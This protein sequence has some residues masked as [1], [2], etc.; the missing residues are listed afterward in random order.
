MRA[1]SRRGR[2]GIT[3]G[4]AG[5][6]AWAGTLLVLGAPAAVVEAAP[7]ASAK[8]SVAGLRYSFAAGG[9][10]YS[11]KVSSLKSQGVKCTTARG[12][13]GRV[14]VDLL[15]DKAVPARIGGLTVSLRM[16]CSG[17]APSYAGVAT[18]PGSRVSF[19]ILGGA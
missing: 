10:T 19:V 9:A 4:R 7:A 14:A 2:R 8:C 15:H 17:C 1:G 3:I 11:V 16:P 13:A 18:G 6:I 5:A 12:L